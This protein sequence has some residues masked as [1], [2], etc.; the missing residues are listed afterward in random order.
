VQTLL[1]WKSNNYCI[2]CVCV[3]VCIYV[4]VCVCVCLALLIHKA[5]RMRHS[6]ICGLSNSTI[7]S[8]LSHK[9]HDFQRKIIDYKMCAVIFSIPF[10]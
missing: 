7:F 3:C 4:C 10:I 1:Q 9:R 2:F 6:V 8:T 5:I